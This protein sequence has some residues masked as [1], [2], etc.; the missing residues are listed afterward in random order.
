MTP[1]ETCFFLPPTLNFYLAKASFLQDMLLDMFVILQKLDVT[2]YVCLGF[3]FC[4]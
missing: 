3:F 1:D 2:R 4:M